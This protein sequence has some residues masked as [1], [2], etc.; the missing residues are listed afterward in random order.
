MAWASN[1]SLTVEPSEI[2]DYNIG[3]TQL[4][5]TLDPN[6]TDLQF[7]Q[8]IQEKLN[9]DKIVHSAQLLQNSANFDL[10]LPDV[11][12]NSNGIYTV[13]CLLSSPVIYE[14][15]L[16]VSIYV[17]PNILSISL[18]Q[19]ESD[20]LLENF[21]NF[22][23]DFTALNSDTITFWVNVGDGYYQDGEIGS[24]NYDMDFFVEEVRNNSLVLD[25]YPN[26]TSY[27]MDVR[28]DQFVENFPF[29]CDF[30]TF[31]ATVVDD[32]YDE[33]LDVV[34]INVTL[35]YAP[36]DL[37][38]QFHMNNDATCILTCSVLSSCPASLAAVLEIKGQGTN[39]QF[40]YWTETNI[41][42][43]SWLFE[44]TKCH[45]IQNLNADSQLTCTVSNDVGVTTLTKKASEIQGLLS[46]STSTTEMT[47]TT[48][49]DDKE[50]L[51]EPLEWWVIFLIC[52]G[53]VLLVFTIFLG[54]ACLYICFRE[55]KPKPTTDETQQT[56][57][58]K[59]IALQQQH[60]PS[61]SS[62]DDGQQTTTNEANP[63][64][65]YS[66]PK[67]PARANPVHNSVHQPILPTS[68]LSVGEVIHER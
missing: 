10:I 64:H 1:V 47:T 18:D 35:R 37:S 42:D 58:I 20:W 23:I 12:F 6:C 65:I 59:E 14:P 11:T 32:Y 13:I 38:I 51:G 67:K 26:G 62:H 16:N 68:Q 24:F 17:K 44:A 22:T 48:E 39:G 27:E 46:P 56:D 31:V 33:T 60:R 19:D 49:D 29:E 7:A 41:D 54:L 21:Y 61:S 8:V 53:G 28:L 50:P 5:F 34:D 45:A 63:N 15:T 4:V 57:G 43:D 2:I 40:N 9:G 52:L 55:E 66:V 36:V 30:S 25:Q 3:T